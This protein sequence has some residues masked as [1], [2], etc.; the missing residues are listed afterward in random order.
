MA[1]LIRFL[2]DH[3]LPS[4]G[5]DRGDGA[6]DLLDAPPLQSP[7]RP[8]GQT[9]LIARLLPPIEPVNIFCIGLN[10]RAHAQETGAPIPEHPVVFMKPTTAAI[11]AEQPI[12]IPAACTHGDEVDY[13][14]ELA[15][16]IGKTTRNASPR[17]ALS[18]VLGYTIANDVSARRWQK[19][20][21]GGQ[22]VRGK[23]FDSFCPLGPALL[24]A[25]P[26]Q[27]LPDPQAL[28]LTTAVNGQT[29]QHTPTAD[30]IFPVA[31]LIAFLSRDTTLVPGTVILTGTPAGVGMGRTPPRYL[32]PG[33][34]VTVDIP[35]IGRLA[36]PVAAPEGPT[37]PD[38]W[39]SQSR[40]ARQAPIA[41]SQ[42]SRSPG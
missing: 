16:V 10:Y 14:G 26:G 39:L 34:R 13:E 4:T 9:R 32:R 30:M 19:H 38:S 11:A 20:A 29:R 6:A 41:D 28:I 24:I 18:H 15:V 7:L 35:P 40:A 27:P 5:I 17:D 37:S 33:D 12:V 23:S 8:T 21:G 2:D 25:S 1:H 36:N 42:D 22:W 3:N 31:D